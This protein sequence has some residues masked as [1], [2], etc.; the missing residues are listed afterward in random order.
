MARRVELSDEEKSA[1][2]AIGRG[3]P[4]LAPHP[5][6]AAVRLGWAVL[7][8][9]TDDPDRAPGG[10]PVWRAEATE[11]GERVARLAGGF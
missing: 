4:T 2:G 3:H 6:E 9:R 11:A 8:Y 7:T 1:L 10:P 5:A